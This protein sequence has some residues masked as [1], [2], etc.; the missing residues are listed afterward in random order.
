MQRGGTI[1]NRSV[2][3]YACSV[4]IEIE[5]EGDCVISA[6]LGIVSTDGH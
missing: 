6:I 3:K 5:S 2:H 4:R 1:I